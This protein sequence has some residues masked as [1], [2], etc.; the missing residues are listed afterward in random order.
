MAGEEGMLVAGTGNLSELMIGYFTKF[1][2]G[3]VDIEPIGNYYKTEVYEMAKYM[4]EIPENI[5][6]KA[7]SANLWDGQ[8]D[9]DEIGF[10]YAKLDEILRALNEN[11]ISKLDTLP[12]DEIEKV[13]KMIKQTAHKSK[14]PPRFEVERSNNISILQQEV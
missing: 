6:I 4:P 2:D 3:G 9:E 11:N 7:P 10:S 14:I 1:G 12:I 5:K 13:Q 8:T